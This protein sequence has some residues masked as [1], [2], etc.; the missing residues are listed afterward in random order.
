[1]AGAE[2]GEFGVTLGLNKLA[3]IRRNL[4]ALCRW[5]QS[6]RWGTALSGFLAAVL[7]GLLVIFAIDFMFQPSVP[8][9]SVFLVAGLGG[10]Y[11]AWRRLVRPWLGRRET[12]LEMALLVQR[13]QRAMAA[14]GGGHAG[15][16]AA[17]A[18]DIAAALQFEAPHAADWGS[19][20]LEQL[21]IDEVTIAA[22]RL[23]VFEGFSMRPAVQ[24]AAIAGAA[25]AVVGICAALSPGHAGA[26]V[27]RLLLGD[28]HYPSRT[29]LTRLWINGREVPLADGVAPSSVKCAEGQPVRFVVSCAGEIPESGRIQISTGRGRTML[30]D[31]EAEQA[32]RSAERN[33]AAK[34][35]RLSER[36]TYQIE[37]GDAWTDPATIELIE[38]P[39]VE[40]TLRPVPPDYAGPVKNAVDLTGTHSVD[41]LEGSRVEVEIAC[42]NKALAKASLVIDDNSYPLTPTDS[43]R[44]RWRLDVR[45]TPL[46]AIAKETRYK[47][48]ILD[49]DDLAPEHVPQGVIRIQ[50]DRPPRIAAV[51]RT[52]HVV[53][54]ASPVIECRAT[55]DYGLAQLL[56]RPTVLKESADGMRREPRAPVA[57]LDGESPLVGGQ[58]PLQAKYPLSLS[59]FKLAKGDQLE[60]VLEVV[61]YRG[62]RA[63]KAAASEPIV[64]VVTD[65]EGVASAVAELDPK[66]EQEF[67]S[68][69]QRQ[70]DIGASK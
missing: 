20:Q 9:R 39:I 25:L 45:N 29:Q 68:L 24:R 11:V 7:A 33:F 3:T 55:D 48:E 65:A 49:A 15:H 54:E 27:N 47:L 22:P 70:L 6:V 26:F 19:V 40:C 30:I 58:L 69:I 5:R 67:D 18:R 60:L 13:R 57:L 10:I 4:L 35:D 21:V 31:L 59:Q 14:A 32:S 50:L 8:V 62:P 36:A 34:L 38:L 66:L 16:R 41:A 64:L 37:L 53:P 2:N 46:E 51:V 23:D 1:V 12:E 44:R 56:V 17:V 28:A 63:G 43:E 52:R 42:R 61:D